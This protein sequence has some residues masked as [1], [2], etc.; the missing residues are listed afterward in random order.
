[1]WQVPY[2]CIAYI[3]SYISWLCLSTF[4]NKNCGIKETFLLIYKIRG[5]NWKK[6]ESI[7]VIYFYYIEQFT[8]ECKLEWGTFLVQL[9]F[10]CNTEIATQNKLEKYSNI[11][12][13]E[14]KTTTVDVSFGWNRIFFKCTEIVF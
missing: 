2:T 8:R 5:G 11:L 3:H 1:M 4:L 10:S 14:I 7:S 13:I 9:T 12:K 6:K